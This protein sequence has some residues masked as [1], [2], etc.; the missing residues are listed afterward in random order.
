LQIPRHTGSPP[1]L[2]PC[3]QPGQSTGGLRRVTQTPSTA[4]PL[5]QKKCSNKLSL[6]KI[7]ITFSLAIFLFSTSNE[8]L[9]SQV[10]PKLN[11]N[12]V[13]KRQILQLIAGH[14]LYIKDSS[15]YSAPFIRDLRRNIRIVDSTILINDTLFISQNKRTLAYALTNGLPPKTEVLYKTSDNKYFLKLKNVNYTEIDFEFLLEGNIV[16]KGQTHLQGLFYLGAGEAFDSEGTIYITRRY[17][18][19]GYTE[20]SDSIFSLTLQ[21]ETGERAGF[22]QRLNNDKTTDIF[23]ALRRIH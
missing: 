17:L 6:M 2:F 1:G 15:L 9:Y 18:S 21:V 20:K 13:N 7:L 10:I 16:S 19:K 23:V 8:Y 12:E 5:A 11:D 14:K 4:V 3:S 22:F